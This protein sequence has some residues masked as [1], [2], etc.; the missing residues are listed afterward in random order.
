LICRYAPSCPSEL[1]LTP[2]EFAPSKTPTT[3][4]TDAA[5]NNTFEI[6]GIQ[7]TPLRTD[8]RSKP[9]VTG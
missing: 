1:A 9:P 7:E 4:T 2:V 3:K 5:S 6:F 8:S